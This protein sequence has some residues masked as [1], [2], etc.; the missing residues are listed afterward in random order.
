LP[1]SGFAVHTLAPVSQ[2]RPGVVGAEEWVPGA[3][4]GGL[5]R[6]QGRCNGSVGAAL[7]RC[8]AVRE[9]LSASFK[10]TSKTR[11]GSRVPKRYSAPSTP[12]ERLLAS[13]CLDAASAAHLRHLLSNLDPV[14]LLDEIRMAQ[15]R[16]AAFAATGSAPNQVPGDGHDIDTLVRG[17]ATAWKS[18]ES[19]PTHRRKAST[20]HWWRTRTDPFEHTW[21]TVDQ[22]LQA[23]PA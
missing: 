19:R 13:G 21:P 14:A 10:L 17:L 1:G 2:E 7:C 5:R 15:E 23:S 12:C 9:L 16:L 8:P 4:S 11:E 3:P 6:L 20:P 18:G 22:W